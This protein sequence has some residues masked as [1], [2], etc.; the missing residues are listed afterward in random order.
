[1]APVDLL[2]TYWFCIA[3]LL[4]IGIVIIFISSIDDIIIDVRYWLWRLFQHRNWRRDAHFPEYADELY[5]DPQQLIAIMIPAWQEAPVIQRMADYAARTFDYENYHIFVG[6]YPNDPDTQ[7]EVDK[8]VA[9]YPNVHKVVTRDPGPTTKADCLNN[10]IAFITA[11]E[12]AEDIHFSCLAYHDAEDIIHPLELRAFNRLVPSFDLVQIPVMPLAR[13]WTNAIGNHY[14][15][16]FS[17]WHGKDML[18]RQLLTGQIP[19]AGVGTAFSRRAIELLEKING[20]VVFDVGSLT[21]DYE[22]GFRLHQV[23]A[24]EMLLHY[25][26]QFKD[27]PPAWFGRKGVHP[28]LCV[29]EYFPN[30]T[31]QAVRQKSR[32]IVG[33]VF[34]GWKNLGWSGAPLMKYMLMRDRKSVIAFPAVLMG[35][36]IVVTVMFN[37]IHLQMNP[38]WWRFPELIPQESWFFVLVKINFFFMCNRLLHRFIFTSRY[39]GYWQGLQALPRILVG[40]IVNICAF[41]RAF[42]QVRNSNKTGR[43]VTWD[44]TSHDFPD[45]HPGE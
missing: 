22:I 32:W 7:R 39:F 16:E 1:M 24:R 23:G 21:E 42:F 29:Q 31:W 40:N 18:V 25:Q 27:K 26:V 8:V 33:I 28:M 13:S 2:A 44:K 35:Y 19:S 12:A 15:D 36:F 4:R 34:Q 14:I 30:H 37:W 38:R 17:E 41:F 10:I 3:I 11:M 43:A 9:K 45:L 6:T 5:Q 20:G